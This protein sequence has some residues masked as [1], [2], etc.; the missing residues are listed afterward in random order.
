M[1]YSGPFEILARVGEAAYKRRKYSRTS[2][3][4]KAKWSAWRE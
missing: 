1:R 2:R 4:S 3:V